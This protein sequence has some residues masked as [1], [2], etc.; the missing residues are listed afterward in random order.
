EVDFA[1]GGFF[2]ISVLPQ[3]LAEAGFGRFLR[4]NH[5]FVFGFGLEVRVLQVGGGDLQAVEEEAGG[6]LF[7]LAF[8]QELNDLHDRE[9]DG[10]GIFEDGEGDT[11][12]YPSGAGRID[13]E[14]ALVPLLVEEVEAVILQGGG[15]AL[16]AV[17]FQ[18]AAARDI[19]A[20]GAGEF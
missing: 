17:D 6:L 5:D 11:C 18:V 12:S 3:G 2:E 13:E 1:V 7:D 14:L 10:V 4:V 15:A 20:E 9:L 16:G 8:A 19:Q